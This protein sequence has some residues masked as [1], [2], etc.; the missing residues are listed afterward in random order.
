LS[1]LPPGWTGKGQQW[2]R[3]WLPQYL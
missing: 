2:N 3:K 1:I